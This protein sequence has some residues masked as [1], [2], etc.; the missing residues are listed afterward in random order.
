MNRLQLLSDPEA[1]SE[2]PL[3]GEHATLTSTQQSGVHHA[4]FAPLHYE[5]N[6]AYPLIIWLHG[7]GYNEMQLQRIMPGV[8]MRNYVA[9]GPRAPLPDD[10]GY[11]W[12]EDHLQVAERSIFECIDTVSSR[13]NV[14]PNRIFLA[15]LDDGGSASIR[16]GLRHPETFAGVLSIGG[17]FPMGRAPLAR[18]EQARD[19]PILIAQGRYSENYTI[20]R[21]CE[22]LRLFHSAGL[23]VTLRQYPCGDEVDSNM[24]R[25]MDAWIMEQVTGVSSLDDESDALPFCELN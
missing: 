11:R 1:T 6:Y 14:A 16:I 22:E 25:D 5:P 13:F 4:I 21:T 2:P 9:C 20:E 23:S 12:S 17:P 3:D 19:L 24:L 10:Q 18:L 15:G 8:S 7:R